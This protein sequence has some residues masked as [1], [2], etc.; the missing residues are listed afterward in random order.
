MTIEGDQGQ[1]LLAKARQLKERALGTADRTRRKQFLLIA[2][3]YEKLADIDS[4]VS[5]IKLVDST[6]ITSGS[7]QYTI[8]RLR[9]K[10]I[11]AAPV[12]SELR[13]KD[14]EQAHQSTKVLD[15]VL[16]IVVTLVALALVL[17][18]G[19]QTLGGLRTIIGAF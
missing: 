10:S 7:P 3:E 6:N 18:P 16:W 5:V 19:D 17:A 12:H 11:P 1:R 2:N 13:T 8:A 9:P 14:T 15:L 4:P